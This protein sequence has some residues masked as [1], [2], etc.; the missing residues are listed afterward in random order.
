MRGLT[1]APSSLG[2]TRD[3]SLR[4][5][6]WR[7]APAG[8]V[9]SNPAHSRAAS[10]RPAPGPARGDALRRPG[11]RARK[12]R[13]GE[14]SYGRQGDCGGWKPGRQAGRATFA[15]RHTCRPVAMSRVVSLLLG[16]ALL[17]GHGAFCRRVVSGESGAA[18][19]AP[20]AGR[21][22]RGARG[23]GPACPGWRKALQG[24]QKPVRVGRGAGGG[25]RELIACCFLPIPP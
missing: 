18:R 14:A 5:P 7:R 1:G 11:S 6:L 22:D 4:V 15:P 24:L 20:Q 21:G 12:S 10:A 25:G 13:Q 8:S 2:Q 23:R 19:R 16:A 17:C 3:A 9:R